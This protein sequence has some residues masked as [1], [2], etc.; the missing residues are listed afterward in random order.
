MENKKKSALEFLAEKIDL[1][2]ENEIEET[3]KRDVKIPEEYYEQMRP[4]IHNLNRELEQKRKKSMRQRWL[5]TAAVFAIAFISLNAAALGTSEAYRHKV[6][7]LFHDEKHGGVTFVFDAESEMVDGWEQYWVPTWIPEGFQLYAT[8]KNEAGLFM[9]FQNDN[10]NVIRLI[11]YLSDSQVS[12]D[13][14]TSEMEQISIKG[15]DG[16]FLLDEEYKTGKFLWN[17]EGVLVELE[18]QGSQISKDDMLKI[19]QSMEYI[20]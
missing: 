1:D 8:E 17:M 15:N 19:A 7:S 18:F 3:E 4:F 12:F 13:T 2:I 20:K 14:D 16:Y 11:E 10:E 5:R 9:M 6:F